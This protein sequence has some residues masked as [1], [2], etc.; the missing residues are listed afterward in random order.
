M[1][2][3]S[4]ASTLSSSPVAVVV[5]SVNS[6]TPHHQQFL[7]Q[8]QQ[9]LQERNISFV[10]LL[11]NYS[12][13]ASNHLLN[14]SS[15]MM[16]SHHDAHFASI[17]TTITNTATTSQ[18]DFGVFQHLHIPYSFMEQSTASGDNNNNASE[19]TILT[20]VAASSMNNNHLKGGNNQ[21]NFEETNI[22]SDY[23]AAEL[24]NNHNGHSNNNLMMDKHALQHHIN[25]NTT[26]NVFQKESLRPPQVLQQPQPQHQ[27]QQ[28]HPQQQTMDFSMWYPLNGVDGVFP[29]D[30]VDHLVS[31]LKGE[32]FN[33]N[34]LDLLQG[35]HITQCSNDKSF[36][37]MLGESSA[38]C[39]DASIA[40]VHMH[41]TC[42]NGH[43]AEEN[44][45]AF[46]PHFAFKKQK[47]KQS[48]SPS[49]SSSSSH[50]NDED[51]HLQHSD[52]IL[53]EE[54]PC[55]QDNDRHSPTTNCVS[56]NK[57]NNHQT[58][59][60]KPYPNGRKRA[61]KACFECQKRHTRC[62]FERPCTRCTKLGLNCVE[63]VSM[64]K[65]GRSTTNSKSK[66]FSGEEETVD[67]SPSQKKEK[68][69]SNLSPSSSS[70]PE[71]ENSHENQ[72]PEGE[73]QQT[74]GDDEPS[75]IDSSSANFQL[76]H[77]SEESQTINNQGTKKKTRSSSKRKSKKDPDSQTN[78]KSSSSSSLTGVG[79]TSTTNKSNTMSPSSNHP[80]P[81]STTSVAQDL[82]KL[83]NP[84][85]S[86]L[87]QMTA[88]QQHKLLPRVSSSSSFVMNRIPSNVSSISSSSTSSSLSPIHYT[89]PTVA[90]AGYG[91]LPQNYSISYA[92]QVPS[93]AAGKEQMGVIITGPN[94]PIVQSVSEG[95][96]DR[97]GYLSGTTTTP[98]TSLSQIFNMDFLN[99]E[100]IQLHQDIK[101][102]ESILQMPG[103]A[104]LL[105][106]TN[107]KV[108]KEGTALVRTAHT[109]L[110]S[111]KFKI[112]YVFREDQPALLESAYVFLFWM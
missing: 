46:T 53:D 69:A 89:N 16:P 60:A 12:S 11:Q 44:N 96:R 77:P 1:I 80:T 62:G 83:S 52:L 99:S 76:P 25:Q 7:V 112:F 107:L 72:R 9:Q 47:R 31:F 27:H 75:L 28:P 94:F 95:L 56:R 38:T 39:D 48:T 49:S 97:L 45:S 78:S 36:R 22:F 41:E 58:I 92:Q 103:G 13:T 108:Q 43:P 111:M 32:G 87:H 73:C 64:K 84:S 8:L 102:R 2:T 91:T 40:V 50:S 71:N 101:A 3:S 70:S 67:L 57:S 37:H 23:S 100:I 110:E 20:P 85:S 109:G 74:K 66:K 24:R 29:V 88:P 90:T 98:I 5:N 63:V 93:T 19:M 82:N 68:K 79:T 55:N 54:D 105:R 17:T 34:N 35:N 10:S 14:S 21:P 18:E 33:N 4:K 104:D 65:R 26:T 61:S 81:T 42:N 6:V 15:R 86:Q 51:Q 59:D 106:K 30:N